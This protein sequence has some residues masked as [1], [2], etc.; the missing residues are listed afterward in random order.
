MASGLSS[1]AGLLQQ[2]PGACKPSRSNLGF[3]TSLEVDGEAVAGSLRHW[4]ALKAKVEKLAEAHLGIEGRLKDAELQPGGRYHGNARGYAMDRFAFSRCFKCREPYFT[5][6]RACGEAQAAQAA[7]AGAGAGAAGE[8]PAHQREEDLTCAKCTL[9][10]PGIKACPKHGTAELEYKCRFCC[11]NAVWF[12]RVQLAPARARAR[13]H[14]RSLAP[15][16]PAADALPRTRPPDGPQLRDDALL[17]ALPLKVAR[18][19]RGYPLPRLRQRLQAR[20][21]APAE[22]R[23][24]ERGRWD[25]RGRHHRVL[26]GV[27]R[28]VLRSTR[29]RRASRSAG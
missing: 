21:R 20:R 5:G 25:G 23:G 28:G 1:L 14:M 18:K 22:R 13:A 16:L 29:R 7:G 10:P 6:A 3:W 12:W 24:R 15:S 19:G 26:R 4:R 2:L 17:R 11:G 9:P 8:L 27:G